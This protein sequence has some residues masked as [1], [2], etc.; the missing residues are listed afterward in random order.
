MA[1]DSGQVVSAAGSPSSTLSSSTGGSL[2]R[3]IEK[4]IS[5]RS[6]GRMQK[7]PDA[8]PPAAAAEA[9][10][11]TLHLSTEHDK[12]D[13]A[14][15]SRIGGLPSSPIPSQLSAGSTVGSVPS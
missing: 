14:S 5:D 3:R 6:V 2:L 12:H 1:A 8:T 9:G 10:R 7:Q 13:S 4:S 15:V 11:A